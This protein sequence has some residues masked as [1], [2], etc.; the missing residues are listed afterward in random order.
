M[1]SVQNMK[2]FTQNKNVITQVP[3]TL[4]GFYLSIYFWR[5]IDMLIPCT[6]LHNVPK[7]HLPHDI[8]SRCVTKHDVKAV[9]Y[10]QRSISI[11]FGEGTTE[12]I[13]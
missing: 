1:R 4:I 2:H 11:T 9:N 3:L 13:I 8:T 7:R 5:S 12:I 10:R 6:D